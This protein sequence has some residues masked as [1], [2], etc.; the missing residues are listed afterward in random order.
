MAD[1]ITAIKVDALWRRLL[2]LLPAALALAVA[3]AVLRW[4]VGST[5]AEWVPRVDGAPD[6]TVAQAAARLAP[7]DPQAHFTLARIAE[8]SFDPGQLPEAVRRYELA[9]SLSPHDYRLW[10]ELGRARG[11]LGDAQGGEAA[12]RRAVELA[13]AYAEPRWYLGNLLLR[14]GR[15]GE[16]F[17]ELR[18]AGDA[19]P[20]KF[21]PQVLS[22]AWRVYGG[23]LAAVLA[24]LGGSAGARAQLIDYLAGQKRLDDALRLWRESDAGA[25]REQREVGER[26]LRQLV[27]AKRFRDVLAHGRE[28]AGG[29]AGGTE[30]PEAEELLNGGF[31]APVGAPGR[32]QFDWQVVPIAGAQ[33]G[34]DERV[35]HGGRR[36]LR[37]LF[38]AADELQFRNV[39]QLVVVEPRTR[40]RLECWV[41]A[42][43]L[44][45]AS[46]PLVEVVDAA[47]PALVL[48]ASRPLPVGTTDWQPVAL[49]FTTAPRAEGVIV[50]LSRPHCALAQ[51]PI[52]GKVWYDDFVLQ[53]AGR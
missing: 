42:E 13:P 51:C 37:I 1:Q 53:R 33:M 10:M 38:D 47:E 9:T 46:T 45:S 35:R 50:R 8:R 49:E 41:R 24:A 16:A 14:Q 25:R 7:A 19:D 3:W 18:R 20:P 32:S 26:L 12:L 34:L 44:K 27:E 15:I 4:S 43:D 21:R 23:N 2:L 6:A 28:L 48:A 29:A 17:A 30:L 52:F 31:E 36:S 40:Y 39:S 22:L 5:M 11:L